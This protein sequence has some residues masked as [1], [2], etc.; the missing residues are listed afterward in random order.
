MTTWDA[1][2]EQGW[3]LVTAVICMALMLT[4]TLASFSLVDTGQ[5]RSREQRERESSLNVAEGVLYGQGFTLA[6]SW[7]GSAAAATAIPQTCTQA[8][9]DALCPT[10]GMITATN[11]AGVD[12]ASFT[13][14]D[15]R[16]GATWMTKIRDNGGPIAYGFFTA[17][18]DA[19]QTG[20]NIQ[21]GASYTCAAPCRWDANGDKQLWVQ[22]R[23]VVRGRARNLVALL[24][25]ENLLEATPETA[26]I[27]GGINIG[28]NGNKIMLYAQGSQ[29]IV[30]CNIASPNCALYKAG[31]IQP[32]PVTGNSPPLMTPSQLARFK[33]RAITDG[34]YFAGCPGDDL[35]GPVVWV[36]NCSTG[37][38]SNSLITQTCN[39]APPPSPGGGGTPLSANC[40]NQYTRPGILIW[41]C[42]RMD[43]SGGWTYR[44]ILYG[45]NNSDGT[46]PASAPAAGDGNCN[47]NSNN[48]S[49]VIAMTGGFGVWGG[50][51]IDGQGCLYAG[52][53]AIQLHYD[54]NVFGAV[55]SYG[56][57]GLVQ[58]TW[59]ELPPS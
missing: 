47:G 18:A 43:F 16:L 7:P 48:S 57:V 23:A 22:S 15:A 17:S 44:G 25:L 1:R 37:Q 6:Q 45:V 55:S 31:Q 56:T 11:A 36:E 34:H 50:I 40:V 29:V 46:C 49:M 41:H 39:P 19:V 58:N 33:Q 5:G 32:A 30:R 9:N 3:V 4:V 14:V 10:P 24:K 52:S 38:L 8:S 26:V 2:D 21:T 28:N 42:G 27:A 35:S 13:N 20:T 54:P 51:A 59:R 12:A 53:N